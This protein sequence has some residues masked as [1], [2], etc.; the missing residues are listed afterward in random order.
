MVAATVCSTVHQPTVLTLVY[1]VV[2]KTSVNVYLIKNNAKLPRNS[3]QNF[4]SLASL[5]SQLRGDIRFITFILFVGTK[6]RESNSTIVGYY[7]PRMWKNFSHYC[8]P[9]IQEACKTCIVSFISQMDKRLHIP[10]VAGDLYFVLLVPTP[11]HFSLKQC[12]CWSV[13][14]VHNSFLVRCTDGHKID[15]NNGSLP[16]LLNDILLYVFLASWVFQL[17]YNH[18]SHYTWVSLMV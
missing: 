6:K 14:T 1:L 5:I 11:L 8:F 9:F 2:F 15:H 16:L 13:W 3:K 4:K 17:S 10:T 18:R 12:V 7:F